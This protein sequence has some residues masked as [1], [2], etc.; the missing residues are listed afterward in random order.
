MWNWSFSDGTW[1]NTS[2][3]SA[4]DATKIYN[5]VGNFTVNLTTSD[6]GWGTSTKHSYV[7]VSQVGAPVASFNVN[8]T[9]G[10]SPLPVKF[11]DTSS[12]SPTAW[13]WSFRNVTGNNT[14][15]TFSTDQNPEYTFG[16]GNWSI[17]LNAT[18]AGGSNVSTQ[19]TFINVTAIPVPT[20]NFVGVPRT[21]YPALEVT[22][23]DLSSNTPTAWNW[24]FGDNTGFNYT[25][26]PV[27]TYNNV[28]NYTVTL[29]VSNIYGSDTHVEIGYINVTIAPVTPPVAS[30]NVNATTGTDPTAIQFTDTSS[31]SPDQWN[32]SFR[33]VTGNNTEVWFSQVQNPVYTLGVGNWSI[34]LNASNSGGSDISS[35]VTFINVTAAQIVLTVDFSANATSGTI[36]LVVQFN[37]IS[38]NG[39]SWYWMFGDGNVSTDRYPLFIYNIVGNFTVNHSVSNGGYT[40]WMNKTGYINTSAL[41]VPVANFDGTPRTGTPPLTVT[42]TDLSS[43]TPT[44]W[45]W[46]FGDGNY[47]S[48]Q[49][50]TYQYTGDGNYTVSLIVS[51]VYGDDTETKTGYINVS[52]V[53]T[54]LN[55]DFVADV[56]NG[57]APLD[58][59]FTDLSTGSP[60]QWNWSF[61]DGNYSTAQNPLHTYVANGTYTVSLTIANG[62]QVDTSVKYNYILV[63]QALPVDV[64]IATAEVGENHIQW[65]FKSKNSTA[66]LPPLNVYL[67]DNTT[68]VVTNYTFSTLLVPN[69]EANERHNIA[70]YNATASMLGFIQTPAKAT[71]KTLSSTNEVYFLI[72]LA[73]ILMVL[74]LI[75]Q[76]LIWLI[77]LSVLNI[78]ITLFGMSLSEGQGATPFIFLGLAIITGFILIVVG[79]PK[80][81]EQMSWW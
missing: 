7:N 5:T 34:V 39:T 81:K 70:V 18:N 6:N 52:T 15:A 4:K 23:T 38:T 20:A 66:G 56:T 50:P 1:Y 77:L 45:N 71:A 32:W 33:N 43:N 49:N 58:V 54:V 55:A 61:G 63:G 59:Q 17:I 53:P 26:N 37:D 69:L 28:G 41:P 75:L 67:D 14:E 10:M 25:Q 72:A 36:P 44:A 62:T 16:V 12:N 47:S 11:T 65:S 21:G 8:T 27:H 73:I 35:Q 13:S 60:N 80:L 42:F 31:N 76:D 51:N 29:I 22:F 40:V 64:I 57:A 24:S 9:S 3:A 74:I 19:S 48:A 30:F 2:T 79:F 78:L 68:P 46:S